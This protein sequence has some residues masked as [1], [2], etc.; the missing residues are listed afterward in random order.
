MTEARDAPPETHIQWSHAV[1]HKVSE[2]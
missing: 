2:P 1:S